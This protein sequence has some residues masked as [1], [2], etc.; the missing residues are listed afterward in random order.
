MK[1]LVSAMEPAVCIANL[2]SQLEG[3]WK[4]GAKLVFVAL[5][6]IQGIL[7]CKFWRTQSL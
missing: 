1:S 7:G 4:R 6:P 2:G 3:R 5:T